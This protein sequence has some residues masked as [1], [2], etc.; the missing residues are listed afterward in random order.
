M[1]SYSFKHPC[2]HPCGS[3]LSYLLYISGSLKVIYFTCSPIPP[4]S[5]A[6]NAEST[7]SFNSIP[8]TPSD[9]EDPLTTPPNPSMKFPSTS[10]HRKLTATL[11][12]LILKHP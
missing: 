2:I 5:P 1:S 8:S 7:S 11:T 10:T 3:W 9:V 12:P 4:P 6:D